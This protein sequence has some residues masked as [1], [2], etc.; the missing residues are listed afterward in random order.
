MGR[1]GRLQTALQKRIR[2]NRPTANWRCNNP[3]FWWGWKPYPSSERAISSL[4]QWLQ[5]LHLV[6]WWYHSPGRR[7]RRERH[8]SQ[9]SETLGYSR[10][11]GRWWESRP[12][13]FSWRIYSAARGRT[14]AGSLTSSSNLRW[15]LQPQLWL[16][17]RIHTDERFHFQPQHR[18]WGQIRLLVVVGAL[19]AH[20]TGPLRWRSRCVHQHCKFF[21][22][23]NYNLRIRKSTSCVLIVWR[24]WNSRTNNWRILR[25]FRR[26]LQICK[27]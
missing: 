3:S 26:G 4:F 8:S 15:D 23:L 14:L 17:T 21:V 24:I 25:N 19:A 11:P 10:S 7:P 1:R 12:T 9:C 2:L 27:G 20:S 5:R 22:G 18:T 13:K 6:D 16:L